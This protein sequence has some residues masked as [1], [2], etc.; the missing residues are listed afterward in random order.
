MVLIEPE[1]EIDEKN[2]VICKN[3]TDYLQFID[4]NK[5]YFEDI[6]LD[7]VLT[8]LTCSHYT[9]NECYFSKSRIDEIEFKRQKKKNYKCK[10]CEQKIERMF[11]IIYKLY[12][13][14]VYG[15]EIPL[16]CCNCYD[17]VSTNQFLSESKKLRNLYLLVILTSIFTLFYSNFLL[18]LL[19][20]DLFVRYL[21][22]IP[23]SIL[24]ISI[25]FK[26][27]IKLKRNICGVKYY[28]KSFFKKDNNR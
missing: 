28:K 17:K 25:I 6:Y 7:K 22:F 23:F 18:F 26:S 16:I 14:E 8:C 15:I 9:Y 19:K 4:P 21:L 27:L 5:D 1:F 12:I 24:I 11:T 10:L 13:K 3:H 2:R 20:L